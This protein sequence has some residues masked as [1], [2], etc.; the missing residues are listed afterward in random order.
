MLSEF[1]HSSHIWQTARGHFITRLKKLLACHYKYK[2]SKVPTT[3][4][5][6]RTALESPGE[7]D[8]RRF[9]PPITGY[10]ERCFRDPGPSPLI[11]QQPKYWP[12]IGHDCSWCHLETRRLRLRS[13]CLKLPAK[14]EGAGGKLRV[15]AM[16]GIR[17]DKY[18]WRANVFFYFKLNRIWQIFWLQTWGEEDW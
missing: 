11:G 4:L 15:R 13:V 3:A 14:A 8:K 6:G 12:L 2:P 16:S 18:F 9:A 17:W 5:D 7:V 1:C 10:K